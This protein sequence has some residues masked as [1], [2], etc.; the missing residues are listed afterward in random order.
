MLQFRPR[1]AWLPWLVGGGALLVY[2]YTAAP[3]IVELFDDSLELQLVGPTLGIAHP[4]GYPLYTLLGGLWS[5]LIFPFGNWAWRMNLF[6]ALAAALAVGLVC[7]LALRLVTTARG[8][9]NPWA[10]LAAAFAFALGPVWWRQATVAEVYALHGLLVA[11]ILNAAV[12]IDRMLL[13][14]QPGSPAAAPTGRAFHRRMILLWLL[15]G[16][17]LAHHRT[18][19]LLLPAVAI[20][21]LWSVPGIWRPQPAWL[22]WFAALLAPLLLY[23]YLPLRAA[24]GVHDLHGSYTNTWQGFLDHV[25]A[26]GYLGFFA[27]N[28]LA[29]H[30]TAGDWLALLRSQSGL[31]TLVLSLFGCAWL[32]DRNGRLAKPWVMLLIALA[33]NLLF[34]A[35]YQVP[36]R[37]VFLVPAWLIGAVFVGGG[38]GLVGRLFGARPPL[39]ATAQALLVLLVLFG[40]GGRG[41]A[42][43]RRTDWAAHDYAT[44]MA[45]VSFPPG[46][47]VIALEGEATA[48]KYMQQAQDL[49]RNA[50]A[51]V[52]DDPTARAA[53]IAAALAAGVP[54]FITR[55]LAGIGAQYSFTGAGP[56]VRVWPRGQT[57]T[58]APANALDLPIADDSLRLTGYDLTVRNLGGGPYLEL[59]LDWLPIAPPA[60]DYKLSLR[61]L[62]ANGAPIADAAGTPVVADLYPLRQVAPTSAWPPGQTV[63]DVYELPIPRAALAQPLQLQMIVYDAATTHEAARV[64]LPIPPV[65]SEGQSP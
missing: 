51:V 13:P 11:A 56:L 25:L 57:E 52:A 27:A 22:A 40:V 24:M 36:D 26:R 46:S 61:L 32:V 33:T 43:N 18:A 48:L 9:P 62:D 49:G 30:F 5:R 39:A 54:T 58:P 7:L 53:A 2:A 21:L 29:A 31:V 10:G 64:H 19:L 37:E 17:G 6:S 14:A 47:R 23:L 65:A 28:P 16:L 35:A 12:G 34:V 63:R 20:Y 55:E 42:V 44:L 8:D 38:V 1:A 41:P 50:T 15:F 3:G 4:T 60:H 59:A 45:T